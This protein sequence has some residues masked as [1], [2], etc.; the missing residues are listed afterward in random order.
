MNG[1]LV[2]AVVLWV[3]SIARVGNHNE[4]YYSSIMARVFVR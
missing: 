4:C 2:A 3:V 1:F